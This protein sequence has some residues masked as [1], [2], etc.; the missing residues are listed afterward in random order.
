MVMPDM[1]TLVCACRPVKTARVLSP[2]N[3]QNGVVSLF[4]SARKGRI[5]GSICGSLAASVAA[6]ADDRAAAPA[7]AATMERAMGLAFM[8]ISFSWR[9]NSELL[10][11]HCVDDRDIRPLSPY[12]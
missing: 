9:L 10:I 4:N 8:L 1:S 5:C 7:R 12:G 2:S 3:S 11:W 6:W